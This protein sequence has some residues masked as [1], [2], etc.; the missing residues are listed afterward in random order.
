M[1]TLHVRNIPDEIYLQIQ[2]LATKRNRSLSAEVVFL[3]QHALD[4]EKMR[5]EQSRLLSDIRR[6]RMAQKR[7][8]K[9]LDSVRL[10]REDRSR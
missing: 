9:A 6:R 10:L 2:A 7:R 3:L 4:E 8:Q 5:R 1:A